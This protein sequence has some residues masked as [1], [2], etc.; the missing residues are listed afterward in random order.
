MIRPMVQSAL[1]TGARYSELARL[2]VGDIN[3]QANDIVIREAKA[4]KPR[5]IVLTDEAVEFFRPSSRVSRRKASCSSVE[6]A[7]SGN[8]RN[9]RAL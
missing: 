6:M 1:L 8:Q 3:P 2:Q 9:K 4:G 5:H 7:I